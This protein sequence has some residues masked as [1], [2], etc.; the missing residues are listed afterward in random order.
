LGADAPREELQRATVAWAGLLNTSRVAQLARGH[1]R[2]RAYRNR[3][4]PARVDSQLKTFDCL[5]CEKCIPVCP[6]AASFIYPTPKVA[7]DFHEIIVSPD[8]SWREGQAGRFQIAREWQLANFADFCNECG[9]CDTFC[10]EYG[11]PYVEKPSFHRTVESWECAAPR[12]GFVI[13]EQPEGGWIRARVAGTVYQLTYVKQTQQYLF[14]DG[15]IEALLTGWGHTIVS[16]RPLKPLTTEHRLDLR[17]YHLLRYLRDGV[18]DQR[19]VNQINV[20]WMA[21]RRA[22]SGAP[23]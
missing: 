15:T 13:H 21:H 8:G 7:F 10:P 1:H 6:N 16:I 19:R 22:A 2:Y 11:G 18:L 23:R 12:D 20:Q 3:H 14:D 9:N 17:I 5:T 4:V